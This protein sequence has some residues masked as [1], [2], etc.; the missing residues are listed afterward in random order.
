[1]RN[2]FGARWQKY[3]VEASPVF[4]DKHITKLI[5]DTEEL[6]TQ[7]LTGGDRRKAMKLLRVPPTGDQERPW[8]VLQSI[9]CF[10]GIALLLVTTIVSCK[11]SKSQ[12]QYSLLFAD[13]IPFARH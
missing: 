11:Y 8:S 4:S 9:M 3:I 6:A 1:M 10:L 12:F 7:E 5:M 2:D 13:N